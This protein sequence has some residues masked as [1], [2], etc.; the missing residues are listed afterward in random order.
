[1][2]RIERAKLALERVTRNFGQ[3][4][5][6]FDASRAGT[7]DDERQPGR[8]LNLIIDALGRFECKKDS[9]PDLERIVER[10]EPRRDPGPRVVAEVGVRDTGR[11]HQVVVIQR[12]RGQLQTTRR[13]IDRD[14]LVEQHANVRLPSQDVTDR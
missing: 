12:H 1:M 13:R 10:L 9:A 4:P 6:Q 3:R 8:A 14:R 5:G 11:D 7:D 2:G